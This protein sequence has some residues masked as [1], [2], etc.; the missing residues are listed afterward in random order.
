MN[1]LTVDYEQQRNAANLLR[2]L[3]LMGYSITV[4]E[5]GQRLSAVSDLFEGRSGALIRS[6]KADLLQLLT[7]ARITTA[8][9]IRGVEC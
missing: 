7:A 4:S 3:R 5:D 6:N 1:H 9:L 2:Y 8:K